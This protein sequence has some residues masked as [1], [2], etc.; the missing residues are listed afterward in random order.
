MAFN[1][2]YKRKYELYKE[3]L[4]TIKGIKFTFREIDIL[5]CIVHNR[6][7][8]KIASMLSISPRTVSVHVYNV[9]N[10]LACNSKD[11]II[12]FIESSGKLP[13]FRE[14]YLHLLFRL[15]QNHSHN[16]PHHLYHL[17]PLIYDIHLKRNYH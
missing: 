2:S 13:L 7:E 3:H 1:T 16:K 9:M 6:G 10:K 12:D 5:V 17:P 4:A 11:Q 15:F 8:K 14:Y